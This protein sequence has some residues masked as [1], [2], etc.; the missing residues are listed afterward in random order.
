M[1]SS[2]QASSNS[3]VEASSPAGWFAGSVDGSPSVLVGG[4]AG[5]LAGAP[6]RSSAI[7]GVASEVSGNAGDAA[8]LNLSALPSA[9]Q[10]LAPSSAR[11]AVSPVFPN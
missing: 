10:E 5:V 8:P 11:D 4:R 9:V 3:L 6:E 2:S 1:K 7:E